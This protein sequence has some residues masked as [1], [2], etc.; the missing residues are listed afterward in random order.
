M[1]STKDQKIVSVPSTTIIELRE[2]NKSSQNTL[3]RTGIEWQVIMK[4]N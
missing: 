3:D 4:Q 1:N 2:Q